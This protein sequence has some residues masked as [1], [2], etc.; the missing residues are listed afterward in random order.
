MNDLIKLVQQGYKI[1]FSLEEDGLFCITMKRGIE[2]KWLI[3]P[4]NTNQ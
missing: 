1:E 2:T 3:R 4:G